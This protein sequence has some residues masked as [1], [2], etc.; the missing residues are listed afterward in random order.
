MDMNSWKIGCGISFISLARQFDENDVMILSTISRSHFHIFGVDEK[1]NDI[2]EWAELKMKSVMY[3][4]FSNTT[5]LEPAV[6]LSFE[7][8]QLLYDMVRGSQNTS[9]L[10]PHLPFWP[11]PEKRCVELAARQIPQMNGVKCPPNCFHVKWE[12]ALYHAFATDRKLRNKKTV[13]LSIFKSHI[14]ATQ[15]RKVWDSIVN[16][17]NDIITFQS[18]NKTNSYT[19]TLFDWPTRDYA[20]TA[21]K[22]TCYTGPVAYSDTF[23]DS[24]TITKGFQ[25]VTVTNMRLQ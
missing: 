22:K 21:G 11:N 5:L 13:Q 10:L 24:Q 9:K 14:A 20:I 8:R 19:Y 16:C 18:V 23:S 15:S 7:I 25:A 17:S 6:T 3:S 1:G 4:H 12:E 2:E